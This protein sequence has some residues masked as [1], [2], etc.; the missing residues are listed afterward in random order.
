MG[1]VRNAYRMVVG[2][3][4]GKRP[5]GRQKRRWEDDIKMDLRGLRLLIGFF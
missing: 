2:K 3:P 4:E 5:H 1:E